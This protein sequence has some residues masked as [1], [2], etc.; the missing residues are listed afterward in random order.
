MADYTFS[1]L[2]RRNEIAHREIE[3]RIDI[4]LRRQKDRNDKLT[5]EE[6]QELAL[7]QALAKKKVVDPLFFGLK[8]ALVLT[9]PSMGDLEE[10]D[11]GKFG[12]LDK[13]EK[14][15]AALYGLLSADN[16]EPR[17]FTWTRR[18]RQLVF[19][20]NDPR[21]HKAVAAA[22]GE[23]GTD[24]ELFENTLDTMGAEGGG[25]LDAARWASVVRALV[26]RGVRADHPNLALL[27]REVLANEVGAADGA[28]PSSIELQAPDLE[29]A[30]D[31]VIVGNN[32]KSM[33]VF[34]PSWMLEEARFYDVYDKIEE[35]FLNQML[36]ISRGSAGD[37]IYALW[38]KSTQRISKPERLNFYASC[39]GAAGGNPALANQNRE[40][41]DLWLRFVSGVSEWGRKLQVDDL[42]RS[43]LPLS[44]STEQV[45]KAARDLAANLS[46]HGYG[47]A[48]FA[49]AELQN[50]INAIGD[51]L[52][53]EEVRMAYGARDMRQLIEQ[54]SIYEL[55]GARD[56]TRYFTMATSGAIVIAW[57]AKKAPELAGS[58]LRPIL[59]INVVR[60]QSL[61][62]PAQ[63]ARQDPNDRDLV[64]ACEQWLAVT[65]TPDDR[66]SEFAQP[67]ESPAMTSRPVAIPQ[68]ARDLL[69]SVGISAGMGRGNG[70]GRYG[71][72]R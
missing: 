51:I 65:G 49:A 39:F 2:K 35:L 13:K 33:L 72:Q 52:K 12:A 26:A 55:G 48:Y 44:V 17:D 23:Y 19:T 28:A 69:D 10:H 37:R 9:N 40:F 18:G 70:G 20:S 30:T 31:A 59:D 14:L 53:D 34:Y 64:D 15:F 1:D 50:E 16:Q 43:R 38:K 46:L 3:S 5:P 54:V 62:Q 11:D 8:G 56:V 67:I 6:V 29:D 68:V 71:A 41:S 60:Q 27:T 45:R 4:L 63:R 24:A 25:T 32:I 21:F 36:P 66:V 61:R 47:V 57:L 22:V 58:Y 7:K 42:L